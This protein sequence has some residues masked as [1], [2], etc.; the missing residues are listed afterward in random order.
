MNGKEPRVDLSAT[1]C[2]PENVHGQL[3]TF[4]KEGCDQ[5][6]DS[7]ERDVFLTLALAIISGCLPE[8]KAEYDKRVYYPNLFAL[9]VAPP[10]NG[11]GII[12]FA[13]LLGVPLHKKLMNESMQS[14]PKKGI[15]KTLYIPA[16]TSAA[17]LMLHLQANEGIGIVCESEADTLVNAFK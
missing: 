17:M 13:K 5:F 12:S 8:V 14:D 4:L 16:D 9:V 10:A 3:P 2:I 7:R 15:K 11:K 1:P 6:A